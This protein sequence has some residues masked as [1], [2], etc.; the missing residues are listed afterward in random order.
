MENLST[1]ISP[2][3]VYK[4]IAF[5]FCFIYFIL[6][7]VLL[8]WS[9]NI[10][11]AYLYYYGHVSN[12]LDGIISWIGKYLFHI[13]YTIVSPY[14]GQHNDR[15]YVYLLYFTMA[16]VE[17]LGTIVWSVLDRKS[18]NYDTLYYW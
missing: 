5:R 6:F 14:D 9:V 7:I 17:S 4:K 13:P 12:I 8:D 10:V 2:W 15:T 11:F 1:Q 16:G 18:A 3:N